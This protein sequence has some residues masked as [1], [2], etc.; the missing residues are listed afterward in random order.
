MGRDALKTKTYYIVEVKLKECKAY[1]GSVLTPEDDVAYLS[2]TPEGGGWNTI[3]T[4]KSN[5]THFDTPPTTVI[6]AQWDGMPWYCNIKSH[7][8]IEVIEKSYF[9]RN[10][11]V[12][13]PR[14]PTQD[15]E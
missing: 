1:N 9:E 3:S 11:N 15:T 12:L 2:H 8:V 5:A 13:H 4:D 6:V 14:K 10:E 7:K